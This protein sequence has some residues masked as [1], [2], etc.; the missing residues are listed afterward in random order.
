MSKKRVGFYALLTGVAYSLSVSN[1]PDGFPWGSLAWIALLPLHRILLDITPRQGFF[2][3]WLA[4]FFSFVGT[5]YWVVVA[6]HLYGQVPLPIS[7]ALMFLLTTYLGLFVGV[8]AWGFLWMEKRWS[9]MAWMFAPCLWVSLE[10]LRTYALSGLPWGL[11]GYSQFQW[12]PIIQIADITSVYGVSFVLVLVNVAIFLLLRWVLAKSK[13]RA[14]LLPPWKP[15][16]VTLGSFLAIWFYGSVALTNFSS[17]SLNS[18]TLNVGVVQANIDQALKWDTAYRVDTIE[19]YARLTEAISPQADVVIWPEAATPFL[20]E[21]EPGYQSLVLDIVKKAQV[22]LIFGS[23]A[24]RRHDD[25]RPY[26]LNSAYVLNPDGTLTGRYDK[27]H[28][29][30]FGEYIP[31]KQLLFFLEKLVVGIGDFQPGPGPTLLSI[32]HGADQNQALFGVAICYE[33]IFPDLVRKLAKEGANFLVTITNDAWFGE[34]VAPYQHF[35]MV[36]FR[37][38]ENRMAFARAA[39]TGISG[40]IDPSGKIVDA[41]PIFTEQ[42]ITY[43]LPL[44]N[45]SSWYT[46]FG[47]VFAWG[48]VIMTLFLLWFTRFFRKPTAVDTIFQFP[49][50]RSLEKE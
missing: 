17:S 34:T 24:V 30:P 20:F 1:L 40:I 47:D 43:A 9:N 14:T 11:F 2:R 3:G 33:V 44:G 10:F 15:L 37:A 19:R 6:M 23:P 50:P 4:G 32:R 25:G 31:L 41:T 49:T 22:P 28:L 27:Q 12:L 13:L 38:V 5:M 21:Q 7:I 29:V 35:A 39:N 45:P 36:V 8:Y 16:A 26:L 48:C 46:Q 42:A 18:R